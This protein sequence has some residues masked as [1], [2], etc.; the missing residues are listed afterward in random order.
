M[1]GHSCMPRSPRSPRSPRAPREPRALRCGCATL[2]RNRSRSSRS[3][4]DNATVCVRNPTPQRSIDSQRA[5]PSNNTTGTEEATATSPCAPLRALNMKRPVRVAP[6]RMALT[7]MLYGCSSPAST[8][9]KWLTPG[10]TVV[11]DAAHRGKTSASGRVLTAA[12]PS[13][14]GSRPPQPPSL[15]RRPWRAGRGRPWAGSRARWT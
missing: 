6:G 11:R 14:R 5:A 10:H 8:R 3:I 13:A 9:V 1:V 15:R 7:L 2:P 12:P 4:A